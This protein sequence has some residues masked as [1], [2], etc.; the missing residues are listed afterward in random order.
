MV[1]AKLRHLHI[2]PRK[3]R[4]VADLLRGKSVEEAQVIL[5][6][7]IKKAGEPILE[8]LKSAI[9]NAKNN[10]QLDPVNLYVSR[11]TVDA[12]PKLKRW[13]ARARGSA[14][15]IE[16]KTSHVNLVLDEI[17]KSP[18]TKKVAAAIESGEVR[19]EESGPEKAEKVA[20]IEK[21]KSKIEIKKPISA[22]V[23]KKIFRRQVF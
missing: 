11:I 5:N 19:L 3:V 22:R 9:A 16:K 12:G 14:Y 10:F 6:F 20:K 7:I 23:M 17:K 21:P 8:L 15:T 2:A 1:T 18:K 4:L 13:R